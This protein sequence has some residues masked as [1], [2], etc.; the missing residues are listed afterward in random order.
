MSIKTGLILKQYL[1]ILMQLIGHHAHRYYQLGMRKE[2]LMCL[3][4]I[5]SNNEYNF[6]IITIKDLFTIMKF[7]KY[8]HSY[9]ILNFFNKYFIRILKA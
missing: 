5:I 6:I 9:L 2:M 7:S 1:N 3:K 4:L 8:S